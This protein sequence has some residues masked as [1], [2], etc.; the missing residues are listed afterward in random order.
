MKTLKTLKTLRWSLALALMLGFAVTSFAGGDHKCDK[1]AQ[2]CLDKMTAS[3]QAKGWLGIE[4]EKTADGRYAVSAV[5]PESPA[6][7]A[8]L[9]VGDVLLALNGQDL[10]A[11]DKTELKK[12]KESL[13]VGSK[14]KY[15]VERSGDKTQVVATLAPV[16]D[17]V[18]A[19]WVGEH[20]LDQHSHVRVAAN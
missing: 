3:L 16:P 18:L 11:E 5:E 7:A 8:G 2:D 1:S 17:T 19:Q 6:A 20:L 12:V 14:V 10:Y 4:T 15:T 13:A 9:R